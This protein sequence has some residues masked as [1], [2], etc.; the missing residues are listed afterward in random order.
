[1][2]LRIVLESS[3]TKT[4]RLMIVSSIGYRVGRGLRKQG[5]AREASP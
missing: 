1:M 5:V 4:R 2:I 3:A